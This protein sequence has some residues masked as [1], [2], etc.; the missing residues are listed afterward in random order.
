MNNIDIVPLTLNDV[1]KIKEIENSQG[2]NII[3]KESIISD[4]NNN[5]VKYYGLK[6]DKKIIGYIAFDYIFENMDIHSIVIYKAYERNGYGKMLLNFAFDVAKTNGVLNVFLEVRTS[7]TKAISLY[8]KIGFKYIN[9][10]YNYY[11]DTHEDA[12]IYKKMID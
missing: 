10:R 1:N 7:N 2:V 8:E 12:F 4:L 11:N 5:T 9:T 3:S 6:L